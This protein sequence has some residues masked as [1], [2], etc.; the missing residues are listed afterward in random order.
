MGAKFRQ[1]SQ[2]RRYAVRAY[3]RCRLSCGLASLLLLSCGLTLGAFYWMV[4]YQVEQAIEM[5]YMK[6]YVLLAQTMATLKVND[7]DL[8]G[9]DLRTS[10][11]MISDLVS[12]PPYDFGDAEYSAAYRSFAHDGPML[13]S[14]CE[15][16]ACPVL[17]GHT[18]TMSFD[19]ELTVDGKPEEEWE[20]EDFERYELHKAELRQECVFDCTINGREVFPLIE[21]DGVR[22]SVYELR[23]KDDPD[24]PAWDLATW[25]VAPEPESSPSWQQSLKNQEFKRKFEH[26]VQ[27]CAQAVPLVGEAL[28]TDYAEVFSAGSYLGLSDT[29]M[30]CNVPFSTH[31]FYDNPVDSAEYSCPASELG[32]LFAGW[33]EKW[34]STKCRP[35]YQEQARND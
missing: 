8:V 23:Y 26:N 13:A 35:W 12:S 27:T 11:A 2:K 34:F 5:S 18:Y 22:K 9:N 6:N 3:L 17:D 32:F 20:A 15:S 28:A 19:G 31:A 14:E 16:T 21:P 1:D 4:T 25:Y 33:D 29:G 30:F 10:A 7:I 24:E